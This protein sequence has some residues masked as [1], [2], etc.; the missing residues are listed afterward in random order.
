MTENAII[1]QFYV[2]SFE[3][4]FFLNFISSRNAVTKIF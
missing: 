1:L 2:L 3:G 4:E